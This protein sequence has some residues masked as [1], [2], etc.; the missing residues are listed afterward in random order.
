MSSAETIWW[1]TELSIYTFEC[2]ERLKPRVGRVAGTT[3]IF[4]G[5][6]S[7]AIYNDYIEQ[8]VV[9]KTER[10]TIF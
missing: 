1:H 7:D 6:K 4:F 5:F 3:H 9:R 2:E 10:K 8:R